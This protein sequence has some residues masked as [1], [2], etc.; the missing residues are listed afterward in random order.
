MYE[1]KYRICD[2]S[3]NDI[4]VGLLSILRSRSMALTNNKHAELIWRSRSMHLSPRFHSI[5]FS[6]ITSRRG[7][8]LKEASYI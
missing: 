5:L 6:T 3:S 2:L 4:F 1:A 8:Q 7:L